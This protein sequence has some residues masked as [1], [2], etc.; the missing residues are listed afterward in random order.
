[1]AENLK[2]IP[3]LTMHVRAVSRRIENIALN[4]VASQ[5]Q[6]ET[7]LLQVWSLEERPSFQYLQHN[8]FR[9]IQNTSKVADLLIRGGSLTSATTTNR[10]IFNSPVE[11][12]SAAANYPAGRVSAQQRSPAGT[13]CR[14]LTS[15]TQSRFALVLAL[16]IDICDEHQ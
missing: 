14:I 8:I 15:L 16:E 3:C 9:I 6:I 13:S 11:A 1:M 2:A 7:V 10:R 5:A 4:A 12:L